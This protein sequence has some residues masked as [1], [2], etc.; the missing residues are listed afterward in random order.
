MEPAAEAKENLPSSGINSS[1]TST[2][3]SAASPPQASPIVNFA[4]GI[5]RVPSDEEA[6]KILSD[7]NFVCVTITGLL[8][9]TGEH[10]KPFDQRMLLL[11]ALYECKAL[12]HCGWVTTELLAKGTAVHVRKDQAH[13]LQSLHGSQYGPYE[14]QTSFPEEGFKHGSVMLH[15]NFPYSKLEAQLKVLYGSLFR[16]TRVRWQRVE[17]VKGEVMWIPIG[18]DI[19]TTAPIKPTDHRL[20]FIENVSKPVLRVFAHESFRPPQRTGRSKRG[21][22]NRSQ[23]Q[24][25]RAS[26]PP[27]TRAASDTT[28]RSND[29]K[30]APDAVLTSSNAQSVSAPAPAESSTIT[31][32]SKN[33]KAA[34]DAAVKPTYA[35]T[36]A[37]SAPAESSITNSPNLNKNHKKKQK[38]KPLSTLPSATAATS[39]SSMSTP[40]LSS[41]HRVVS[42]ATA[43]AST[44]TITSSAT[45]PQSTSP[46]PPASRSAAPL[47]NSSESEWTTVRSCRRSERIE[48]KTKGCSVSIS[49]STEG[50]S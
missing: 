14:L 21:K 23:A 19:Y 48:S 45:Q 7:P 40:E 43:S 16:S 33:N 38:K 10:P 24:Q 32:A 25:H 31:N 11:R 3:I 20:V 22:D 30:T 4:S 18:L 17:I 27:V 46:S 35:R 28:K 29:N 5:F 2:I 13:L 39:S 44:P 50:D 1:S 9:P 36:V 6:K 37:A 41:Q 26:P 8:P 12:W 42:D 15:T 34:S 49:P 47:P